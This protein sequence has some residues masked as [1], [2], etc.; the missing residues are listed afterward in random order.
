MLIRAEQMFHANSGLPK[1]VHGSGGLKKNTCN[2]I[3][4]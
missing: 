4:C 2:L 3:L 1:A